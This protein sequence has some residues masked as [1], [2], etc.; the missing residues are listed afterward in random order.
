MATLT[1]V[2]VFSDGFTG[3]DDAHPQP[4]DWD[5]LVWSDTASEISGTSGE[6]ITVSGNANDTVTLSYGGF[7][8]SF[9]YTA[10]APTITGVEIRES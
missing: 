3:F 5:T 4:A 10:P 1:A 8:A 6:S 7:T 2:A 9:D